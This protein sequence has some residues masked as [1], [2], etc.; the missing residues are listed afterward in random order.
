M[1]AELPADVGSCTSS[2]ETRA[3]ALGAPR[4]G[5]TLL[6]PRD[7][8]VPVLDRL[9]GWHRAYADAQAVVHIRNELAAQ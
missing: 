3:V 9:P 6:L 7:G 2:M 1:V 8:A 5:W 4:I